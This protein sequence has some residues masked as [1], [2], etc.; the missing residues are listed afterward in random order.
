MSLRLM[1]APDLALVG[2]VVVTV[3]LC[4]ISLATGGARCVPLCVQR[5]MYVGG[6]GG[7]SR[8]GAVQG[9]GTGQTGREFLKLEFFKLRD[10]V[11]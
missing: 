7:N 9:S 4:L 10:Q 3:W 11:G 2:L 6:G 1:H 8:G 5:R